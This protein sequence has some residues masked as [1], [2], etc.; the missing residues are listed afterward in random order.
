M[1][2]VTKGCVREM[3]VLCGPEVDAFLVNVTKMSIETRR[4]ANA[5]RKMAERLGFDPG[6]FS[7]FVRMKLD[8]HTRCLTWD[9]TV[10]VEL[11]AQQIG[12][13]VE[14]YKDFLDQQNEHLDDLCQDGGDIL[15]GE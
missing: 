6:E 14:E 10:P 11:M 4:N 15:N 5:V 7:S 1:N 8:A 9:P 12:W 2:L 13:T 3:E